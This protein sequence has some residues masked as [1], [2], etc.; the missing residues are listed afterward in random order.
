MKNPNQE[1]PLYFTQGCQFAFFDRN[2]TRM[3]VY[4]EQ[5][6]EFMGESTIQRIRWNL[7]TARKFAF[8]ICYE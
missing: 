6:S 3:S 8:S 5:K 2:N 4:F 1:L 7:I